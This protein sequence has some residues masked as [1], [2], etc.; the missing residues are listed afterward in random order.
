MRLV[1]KLYGTFDCF[2]RN[3]S[4]SK[5][6]YSDINRL[7]AS[8][9]IKTYRKMQRSIIGNINGW[10]DYAGCGMIANAVDSLL[11]R[12]V[13]D[14]NFKFFISATMELDEYLRFQV[15]D[16]GVGIDSRI[17]PKRL[18]PIE[19]YFNGRIGNHMRDSYQSIRMHLG[20]DM[21]LVNKGPNQGAIFW[22]EVPLEALV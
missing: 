19:G 13:D 4:G 3:I 15:E 14:P 16:N 22:Y 17:E 6:K 10:L 1:W 18:S 5:D 20:G 9:G 8:S 2:A 11:E 21:G 12:M 7:I